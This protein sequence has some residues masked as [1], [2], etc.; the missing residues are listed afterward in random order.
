ML[1]NALQPVEARGW[2]AGFAN[3]LT[4]ET[5]SWWKTRRWL[6]GTLTWLAVWNGLLAIILWVIPRMALEEGEVLAFD[7]AGNVNGFLSLGGMFVTI[8]VVLL[9]QGSILDE[10]LSG[11][12]EMVLAKPVSR[13]AVILA[14]FAAY[15]LGVLV[16][17]ILI[18]G[19]VA[20]IQFS[21]ADGDL[22]LLGFFGSMLVAFVYMLFFLAL[23]LMLGT[24]FNSRGMVIGIPLLLL[25]GHQMILGILPELSYYLPYGLML[26]PAGPGSGPIAT[27]LALGEPVTTITPLIATIIWTVIFLGVAVWRFEKEEF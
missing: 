11:T 5:G 21:V 9:A 17:M 18:Q 1:H 10:R 23:T 22:P 20:Y 12:L 14:K 26:A 25:L 19:V 7:L 15:G 2:T 16:T 3:L 6:T 27:S 13:A 8:G 4:K 24:L